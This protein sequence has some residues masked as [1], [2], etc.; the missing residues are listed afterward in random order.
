MIIKRI[1]GFVRLVRP[2]NALMMGLAVFVSG[3]IALRGQTGLE[4]SRPLFLGFVTSSALTGSAMCINDFFDREIDAENEPDRPIPSE[5]VRPNEAIYLALILVVVGL[6]SAL[7][8][9]L[10]NLLVA[11][12]ALIIAGT[13]S[14][15][16]SGKKRGFS[17]N[18]MVGLCIAL[19][20]FYGALA[21][22]RSFDELL[23][24]FAVLAFLSNLGREVTKGI[25]DCEG[26]EPQ[27]V[28]TVAVLYGE[29][30]AAAVAVSLYL[31]SVALS[32]LPWMLHLVSSLYLPLVTI[33]DA[34]FVVLSI[35]LLSNYSRANARR[36]KNLV[37]ASMLIGLIAFVIGGA[38]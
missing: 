28:R 17:G 37:L 38:L 29:K 11:T 33:A 1:R 9:S 10:P 35:S 20:F 14:Y 24:I 18:C 3:I 22:G 6:F 32:V 13:Y 23:T 27:G 21:V 25:V 7:L 34:V 26:D 12:A 30:T 19:P 2:K 36:V 5:L 31:S 8:T 4:H 15:R 16:K